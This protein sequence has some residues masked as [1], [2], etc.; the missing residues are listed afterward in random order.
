MRNSFVKTIG[1]IMDNNDKVVLL[2]GDIGGYL[3]RDIEAKHP[4]RFINAG[5]AEAN[6]VNMAVGLSF[7]GWIPFVYTIT[8]FVT[9]RCYDQIR[10][11]AGYN[12]ANIKLVGVGSG[13][14][15]APLGGTHH[16]IEDIAIMRVIP[17]MI[18]ISPSDGAET[19]EAVKKAAAHNGPV[20]LRL[21]LNV[22][23]LDIS[24]DT[25]FEIG[26][27]RVVRHGADMTIFVTGEL[28]REVLNASNMLSKDGINAT[29]VNVS[30]I[31]PFD[32]TSIAQHVNSKFIFT[33]EE[34]ST[35]GGLGSAVA[36]ALFEINNG[37]S[38]T[39]PKLMKIGVYDQ[40]TRQ[41]GHK[42]ELYSYLGLDAKSIYETIKNHYANP[43]A[44]NRQG[45]STDSAGAETI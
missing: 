36:D 45:Y 21:M 22:E 31:K 39:M 40:I 43:Q 13:L 25:P 15:Y 10:V 18:V 41:Y 24:Y 38:Y 33:V 12:Q 28:L 14:S 8:P 37:N 19:S 1:E 4:S 35:V 42:N 34:H 6:M 29:I 7:D 26:R 11:G 17:G 16:S 44:Y 20:Y 23:P 30:T 2:I 3:M 27:N 5:I 32:Y 9:S